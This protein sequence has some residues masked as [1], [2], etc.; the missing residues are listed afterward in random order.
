MAGLAAGELAAADPWSSFISTINILDLGSTGLVTL[1]VVMIL[2]GRLVPRSVVEMWKAAYYSE[3][4]AGKV[5]DQHI[6][7]LA[8]SA[9]VT[10]RAL[11]SLPKVAGGEPDVADTTE[12]RRRRRQGGG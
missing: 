3:Q 1:I 8:G 12:T 5:K 2:T 6:A 10:A 7:T 4:A 9:S 11:D